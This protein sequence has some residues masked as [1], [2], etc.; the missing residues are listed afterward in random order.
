MGNLGN[1]QRWSSSQKAADGP[2]R[3]GLYVVAGS[4]I[5]GAA[6]GPLV[7]KGAASALKVLKLKI[8]PSSLAAGA[9]FTLT[10]TANACAHG[11]SEV[12]LRRGDTFN[13]PSCFEWCL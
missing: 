8:K 2:V 5:L 4:F 7:K 1:Y 9:I 12:E 10:A 13:V 6:A 3:L 11:V